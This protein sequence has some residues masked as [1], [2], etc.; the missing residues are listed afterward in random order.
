[1]HTDRV[2]IYKTN[3]YSFHHLPLHDALPILST[4]IFRG[5]DVVAAWRLNDVKQTTDGKLQ[6]KALQSRYRGMLNLSYATPLPRWQVDFT[7][8]F[9]GPGRIPTTQG[10]MA[11]LQRPDSF[12]S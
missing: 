5:F 6:E 11:H 9:A 12:N 3:T 1:I 7:A 8:Q 10:N 2:Y 4:E